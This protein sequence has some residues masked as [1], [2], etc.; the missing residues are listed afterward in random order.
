VSNNKKASARKPFLYG[1]RRTK[2]DEKKPLVTVTDLFKAPPV[3]AK[4]RREFTPKEKKTRA[5][6][7]MDN[8]AFPKLKI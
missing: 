7:T 3:N 8:S 4:A 5:P 2:K 6:N 1:E